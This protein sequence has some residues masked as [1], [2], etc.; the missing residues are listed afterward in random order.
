MRRPECLRHRRFRRARPAPKVRV[1]IGRRLRRLR[2]EL[3]LSLRPTSLAEIALLVHSGGSTLA[4]IGAAV[5]EVDDS[6]GMRRAGGLQLTQPLLSRRH[7]LPRGIR[8]PLLTD[9]E[10]PTH[11]VAKQRVKCLDWVIPLGL[12]HPV[13]PTT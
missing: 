2:S 8:G 1:S 7:K 12:H 4:A 3:A 9:D 10:S 5:V 11:E 6:G 13:L